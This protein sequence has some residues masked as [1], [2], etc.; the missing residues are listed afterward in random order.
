MTAD[1]KMEQFMQSDLQLSST[2]SEKKASFFSLKF[3]F[4]PQNL[5]EGGFSVRGP[6]PR[7]S[8]E[9][10][11]SVSPQSHQGSSLVCSQVLAL[12]RKSVEGRS[13]HSVGGA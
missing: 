2:C 8:A 7:A 10:T 4:R 3:C 13:H 12:S 9:E 5:P 6:P 1:R 11:A